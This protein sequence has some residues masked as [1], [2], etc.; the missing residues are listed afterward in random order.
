MELPEVEVV[1]RDLE[2]DVV[3]RR[4]ADVEVR[5][6]KNSKRV[7]R[8]HKTPREFRDRLKGHRFTKA[9]RKGKYILLHLEDG[10]VLVVHFGMSGRFLRGNKRVPLDN[11]THVIITFQQG[12]ISGSSIPGRSASCS[13]GLSMSSD[14]SRSSPTS[15][16]IRSSPR[17]P[18][19]SSRTCWPGGPR[20]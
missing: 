17:S 4:I 11:H 20:S 12:A 8:R 7:I 13:S 10:N 9:D 19:S 6:M 3:G 16:S 1:R 2:K 18:G 15:R 14:G 5:R